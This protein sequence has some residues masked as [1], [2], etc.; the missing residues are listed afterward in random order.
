V[1]LVGGHVE[2]RDQL[3][4]YVQQRPGVAADIAPADTVRR[5]AWRR[6]SLVDPARARQGTV[7][8]AVGASRHALFIDENGRIGGGR[9]IGQRDGDRHAFGCLS[10]GGR[11][12]G[13]LHRKREEGR[14][15]QPPG[16][17]TSRHH[18]EG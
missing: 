8:P 9:A 1:V 15:S 13:T 10:G 2:K 14:H 16:P 3:I 5:E 17:G 11:E 18:Y 7:P 4:R 12:A 6:G